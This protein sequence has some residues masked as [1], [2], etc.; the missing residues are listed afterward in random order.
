MKFRVIALSTAPDVAG[1]RNLHG[2]PAELSD[3]EVAEFAF[4]R[5][6]AATGDDLLP[7]PLRRL[8]AFAVASLDERGFCVFD[9]A[10]ADESALLAAL[11]AACADGEALWCWNRRE[12][13]FA[14]LKARSLILVGALPA[15]AVLPK[16]AGQLSELLEEAGEAADLAML[17]RL[18]G[19]PL[20]AGFS[21]DEVWRQTLAGDIGGLR[22]ATTARALAAFLLG[23]RQFRL[24]GKITPAEYERSAVLVRESLRNRAPD[25]AWRDWAAR[26]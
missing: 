17:S 10:D 11:C 20:A 22:R 15:M 16:A 24:N 26:P 13:S 14:S 19:L 9:D 25:A 5:R 12:A 4:Q 21:Q 6:R 1:L 3:V 8:A 2:L 23:L 7:P 18:C